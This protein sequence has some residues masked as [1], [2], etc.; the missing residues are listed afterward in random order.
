MT[1]RT[2]WQSSAATA[3]VPEVVAEGLRVLDAVTGSGGPAFE[4]TEYDLG[5]R[6]WQA[7][8]E[9]LPDSVLERDPRARRHPARRD[10][11]PQRAE[12]RARARAAA[13]AAVRARPVREPAAQ[14]ALP[15]GRDAAGRSRRHRL[16][17]RPGGHRGPVHRQR[18]RAAGRHPARGRDRGQRQHGVRRRAGRPG[19]VRPGAGPAAPPAHPGAQAQRADL[20]RSPVAAD[21]GAGRR[22]VP[23]R[24]HRLPARRRGDHLPGHRPG[25]VRRRRDRQPVRRHH[26]RPGGGGDRWHRSGRERQRQPRPHG[27]EHVRA[28]A[29]VRPR[30]RGAGAGRPDRHG[31]VRGDAARA[32]GGVGLR[33]PRPGRRG[34]GPG[35]T[36]AASGEGRARWARRWRAWWRASG[37][38][39]DVRAA[40]RAARSCARRP[41]RRTAR[42]RPA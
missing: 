33:R 37:S 30:H 16:R 32:P 38:D 17:R 35:A 22:G 31:A 11:R 42:R 15:G 13:A 21:R 9:T 20:R 2:R 14:P 26:H 19:R 39:P 25:A 36:A 7:S 10:R 3:S 12:R 28:R 1:T 34:E 29:R 27:A 23:G 40:R 18:W 4:R 6:R 5:A 8:G 41:W 24:R